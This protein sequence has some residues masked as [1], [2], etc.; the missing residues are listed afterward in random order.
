MENNNT[1]PNLG[2]N[3]RALRKAFGKSLNQMADDLVTA[4]D[5][6]KRFDENYRFI[7]KQTISQ[8]ENG[9]RI[10]ERE[11]L[12]IIAKYFKVTVDELLYGD[13][14]NLKFNIEDL[15]KDNYTLDNLKVQDKWILNK[16]N[17]L[18]KSTI[19][20]MDKY[21]FNVVG[22]EVYNFVWGDFCDWYIE[23]AKINMDNTTKS[24]LLKVLTD[25]LK[26][27]H[28]F[29]PFVTEEIYDMLPIRDSESIMI[30][31]YPTYDKKYVFDDAKELDNVIEFIVKARNVKQENKIPK[32]ALVYFNGN[33]SDIILKLLKVDNSLLTNDSTLDGI[34]AKE[35]EYV[36]KYMFDMS[37]NR[38]KEM[39]NLIKEKEAL[40]ASIKRRN[41]LLANQNYV[42]K[43]P[44]AIVNK[45]RE[46]LKK[47][48]ERL[49]IILNKFTK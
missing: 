9:K 36:I 33:Y 1:Y 43:A 25:I 18:I 14:T 46:D 38:E 24:V 2:K 32:D 21:E 20:H 48:K 45:E 17:N 30:S 35:G 47:E 16:C 41:N 4:G 7:Q 34:T 37:S 29:M 31:S 49:D 39:E 11:Y 3:I 15:N 44:L 26:M 12:N 19:K 27:L 13:F 6:D 22:T 23:L 5:S 42:S 28:P 10:P 40:E 8:Y